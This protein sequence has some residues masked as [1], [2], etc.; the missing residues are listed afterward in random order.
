MV[1][2]YKLVVD[3]TWSGPIAA[4]FVTCVKDSCIVMLSV[5]GISEYYPDYIQC[6]FI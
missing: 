2:I 5:M 1:Y 3:E 6:D 4:P